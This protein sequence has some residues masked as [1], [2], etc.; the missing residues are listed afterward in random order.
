MVKVVVNDRQGL[1]QRGGSGIE[2]EN[3]QVAKPGSSVG[4]GLVASYGVYEIS[5]EIDISGLTFTTTDNGLIRTILSVPANSRVLDASIICTET[6]SSNETAL[7]DIVFTA[8]AATASD[9]AITSTGDI[10]DDLDMKSSS[11]GTA[12]VFNTPGFDET[13]N[14]ENFIVD[15]GATGN[16]VVLINRS[17]GNGTTAK[18]SGKFLLTIKYIGA[19]PASLLKT[20]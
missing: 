9:D 13:T 10:F 14:F 6:V 11:L 7:V 18:T 12:G 5:A 4:H 2:I 16:K 1:V 15:S 3:N 19:G 20:V 17:T 8:D